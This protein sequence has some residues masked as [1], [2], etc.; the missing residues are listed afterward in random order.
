MFLKHNISIY[1]DTKRN[2]KCPCGSNKIFK[3]CC[4]KEYREM[5]KSVNS[6]IFST[7]SPLQSLAKEDTQLFQDIYKD[8]LVFTHCYKNNLP[9]EASSYETFEFDNNEREFLYKNREEI[10]NAFQ[11]SYPLADSHNEIV[12][13]V[14]EAKFDIFALCAYSDKRAIVVDPKSNVYNVQSLKIPFTQ[15]FTENNILIYSSLIY[16]KGRYILDGYHAF[17]KT[18]KET[19][20]EMKKLPSYGLEVNFKKAKKVVPIPVSINLSLLTDALHY[21][22]MEKM[23]LENTSHQFTE[24]ILKLFDNTSFERKFLV[25]SFIRSIDFLYYLEEDE[26]T[27]ANLINGL[28][29]SNFE[30]NGNSS[31]IPYEILKRYYQEKSLDK[32][33][34]TDIS[35]NI[36]YGKELADM[37]KENMFLVSSFYTMFGVFYIDEDK[38]D[39]FKFLTQLQEEKGR[40]AFTKVIEEYFDNINQDLDFDIIPVYLD[41]GLDYDDIGYVINEYRESKKS[42]YALETISE[43]KA[44]SIYKGAREESQKSSFLMEM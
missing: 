13:A 18:S 36:R 14:R 42:L 10:L 34:S 43:L 7:F 6:A 20:K 40:R 15:L 11:K 35:K 16:Y 9:I 29:V 8:I 41:F 5:R 32:S 24:D 37:G 22:K 44:Y 1:K 23:V 2:E 30:I 27:K 31:V 21:E 38:V 12:E 17:I 19:I 4:M 25:S 28:P 26:L 39:G 3:K 33:V